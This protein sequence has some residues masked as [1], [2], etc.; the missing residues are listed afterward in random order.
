[1]FTWSDVDLLPA[2]TRGSHSGCVLAPALE[3]HA[4]LQLD[5]GPGPSLGSSLQAGTL[6]GEVHRQVEQAKQA[7]EPHTQQTPVSSNIL[8][9]VLSKG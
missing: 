4:W 9:T 8:A 1:M 2:E 7:L 5:P 6:A 3:T